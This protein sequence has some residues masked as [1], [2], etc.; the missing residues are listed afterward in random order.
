LVAV[1]VVHIPYRTLGRF[2]VGLEL[3]VMVAQEYLVQAALLGKDLLEEMV[4]HHN[5]LLLVEV[6][7]GVPERMQ[8]L[9]CQEMAG[10]A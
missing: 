3:E 8:R 7:L 4:F 1:Q 5:R 6:A 10:Q 9:V 2:L